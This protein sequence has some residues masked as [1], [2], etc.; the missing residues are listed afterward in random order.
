MI[1][2]HASK[3]TPCPICGKEDW[4]TFGDR[5]ML[6]QRVASDKP[7]ASTGWYHF[8]DQKPPQFE[9]KESTPPPRGINAPKIMRQWRERTTA[10]QFNLLATQLGVLP[11]SAM[12]IGAAWAP[13]H[14]AWA[15]PMKDGHGET[16]G[17]RLR[18]SSGFKWAV[19]GSKQGLFLPSSAV[20][21]QPCAYLPEG[22]TDTMAGL[23]LGM[24]T[25]GRPTNLVGLEHMK[26][27]LR[28]LRIFK[29]IV[30]AD[31]DEEKDLGGRQM[32]PGIVGAFKL[33]RE[34]GLPSVVWQPTGN[35][36]DL[37]QFCQCG[38]TKALIDSQVKDRIWS[39]K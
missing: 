12:A 37:R 24:Y 35:I 17:I 22:P 7:H 8:Y 18:N 29:V 4:C 10:L 14:K 2:T 39:N 15:F 13:E 6:C 5:A 21:L 28:R 26:V 25:I 9:R 23:S 38:G 30:I 1:W 32:R 27:A 36:K 31:N 33:K 19:S 16:V 20:R 3:Q 34:L 11:E